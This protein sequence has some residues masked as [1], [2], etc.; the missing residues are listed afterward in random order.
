M[1]LP[2]GNEIARRR[3]LREITQQELAAFMNV[4]KASVSKW[5]TGQSYPDITSL[6]LL[7]AYFD[8]SVDDLL[9]FDS[10]LSPKEIQR[11]YQ[12]LKDAFQTKTPS[13]VLALAQSFIKR[14][15]SC[16]PFLLQMGSFYL[17]HWDLLP[18]VPVADSSE[19]QTSEEALMEAKKTTYLKEA[20]ILY[21]R[22]IAHGDN[23]LAQQAK[24][25]EAYC[26][27]MRN[28][29]D[30]VLATLGTKSLSFL[31]NESL[32]AAAYQQ[33]NDLQQAEI[34]YQSTIYQYL[35]IFMSLLT[36]YLAMLTHD[37]NQMEKTFK[38]GLA[39]IE[40][41]QLAQLHPIS[42]LN[43]L[44]AGMVSFA[45]LGK[46]DLLADALAKYVKTVATTPEEIFLKGDDY[47]HNI[48]DWISELELGSQIPRNSSSVKKQFLELAQLTPF[49][50]PYQEISPF[51][52]LFQ[53][54]SK[55]AAQASNSQRSD[56]HE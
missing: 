8:C 19:G 4:S 46:E 32:I 11:I 55:L 39:L 36:N 17:N 35:I 7:A 30:E 24:Q 15:Y 48:D 14:Y 49:F 25:I 52:E 43:F 53:R 12:L 28:K 9:I 5:E 27:L 31:P 45:A 56:S 47:F 33:K 22:I 26:L 10:Q 54:L 34:V 18:D 1:D 13:E 2:I 3:K 42:V 37:E 51:K 41:F 20:E 16:Y 29:P 23:A 44:A 21:Q 38:R 40:H 50:E 6:P